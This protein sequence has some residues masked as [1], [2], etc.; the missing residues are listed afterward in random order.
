MSQPNFP[1]IDPPISR[2]EALN[3]IITSI[4]LEELGFSHI[5]NSEGEKIQFTLG[6]LPGLADGP[7]TLEEIH[8][9]NESAK[10]ILK[11]VTQNQVFLANKFK[12]VVNSP[13]IQGVTGVT[14][15]TG[16]TLVP[17]PNSHILSSNIVP[18]STNT[19]FTLNTTGLY[20]ISYQVNTTLALLLGTRL[21]VYGVPF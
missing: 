12:T 11:Q 7:P 14:G 17:L 16:P 10:N 9:I 5:L 3:L 18:N 1:S 15:S 8:Q 19:I 13:A 2:E 21:L 4:A 20:R 6:T